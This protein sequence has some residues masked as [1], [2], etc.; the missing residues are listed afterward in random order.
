MSYPTKDGA[1]DL[2]VG[3]FNG[4]GN[5]DLAVAG[6]YNYLNVWMGYG[7]GGLSPPALYPTDQSEG[8]ASADLNLD[9]R[10]DVVLA[11]Y[12]TA[13]LSLFLGRSCAP[14]IPSGASTGSTRSSSGSTGSRGSTGSSGSTGGTGGTAGA[15]AIP[16]IG[17]ENGDIG[18]PCS[19][20]A[21]GGSSCAAGEVC[22]APGF[23]ATGV[24]TA[25]ADGGVGVCT[26]D[27][28][29]GRLSVRLQPLFERQRPPQRRA[30]GSLCC[31]LQPRV[32]F[33]PELPRRQRHG[34]HSPGAWVKRPGLL[35]HPGV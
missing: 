35:Q 28:S 22:F 9:G 8:I 1:V 15:C 12:G 19:V 10:V 33:V 11:N 20:T 3:D 32:P 25:V 5:L 23:T 4:D 13:S 16:E 6:G 2:S 21:D 17:H 31:R 7:D 30:G 27:C 14:A 26:A 24:V 29:T 18:A 34:V